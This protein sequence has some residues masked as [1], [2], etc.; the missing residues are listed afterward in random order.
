MAEIIRLR[1]RK[2]K[3]HRERSYK[4]RVLM[5]DY[6]RNPGSYSTSPEYIMR[7]AVLILE[8]QADY[9]TATQLIRIRSET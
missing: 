6:L 1:A 9:D 7:M 2:S 3:H 4:A 5:V 8:G